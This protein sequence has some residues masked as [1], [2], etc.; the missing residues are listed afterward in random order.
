MMTLTTQALTVHGTLTLDEI[1]NSPTVAIVGSRHCSDESRYTARAIAHALAQRGVI[2]ISGGAMGIDAAAHWGALSTTPIHA[3]VT[4]DVQTITTSPVPERDKRR[5]AAVLPCGV[6]VT[7]PPTHADLFARIRQHGALLSAHADDEQP[8]R[9][10][11]LERN[12]VI[13]ALSRAVLIVEAGEQS[14]S[15]NTARH[16]VELGRPLIA[17]SG[18]RGADWLITSGR[19]WPFVDVTELLSLA[20]VAWE[21]R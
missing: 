3:A 20:G 15:L 19:A 18:S 9:R 14:G 7:Y 6:N 16:A 17:M 11:F 1:R 21:A 8:R 5:T 12:R 10:Y 4:A 2:V 13:A